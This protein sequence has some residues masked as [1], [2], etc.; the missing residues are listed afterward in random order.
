[1]QRCFGSAAFSV[2]CL[3]VEKFFLAIDVVGC[4]WPKPSTRTVA[5]GNKNEVV[6]YWTCLDVVSELVQFSSFCAFSQFEVV[7]TNIWEWDKLIQLINQCLSYCFSSMLFGLSEKCA[8]RCIFFFPWSALKSLLFLSI[9][10]YQVC[11]LTAKS[12]PIAVGLQLACW[13]M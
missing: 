12:L 9:D 5:I 10:L 13:I 6:L 3:S 8:A 7:S 11:V 4:L 2:V 1:M